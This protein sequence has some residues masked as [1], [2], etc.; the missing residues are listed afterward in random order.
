[1]A[2]LDARKEIIG[3]LTKLFFV[4]VGVLVITVSGLITLLMKEPQ[5]LLFW[6]GI[7]FVVACLFAC[8]I[9]FK[10]IGRQIEEIRKL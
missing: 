4:I 9:I 7:F 5:S 2:E 8:V 10:H 1:M 3:F 6:F